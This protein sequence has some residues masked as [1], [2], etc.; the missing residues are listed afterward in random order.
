[1][2]ASDLVPGTGAAFEFIGG[3]LR[4]TLRSTHET[5][6]EGAPRKLVTT[7]TETVLPRN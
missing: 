5:A 7:L 4:I 1:V 2:L 6:S 3:A